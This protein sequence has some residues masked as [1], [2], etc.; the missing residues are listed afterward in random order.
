MNREPGRGTLEPDLAAGE[1]GSRPQ[2]AIKP[3][4]PYFDFYNPQNKCFSIVCDVCSLSCNL[5]LKQAG[6]LVM[7]HVLI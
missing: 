2:P 1:T 5:Q 6:Q 4:P 3:L 7:I